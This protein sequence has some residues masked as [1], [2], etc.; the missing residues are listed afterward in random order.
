MDTALYPVGQICVSVSVFSSL[1]QVTVSANRSRWDWTISSLIS[2]VLFT[3]DLQL[4]SAHLIKLELL[5]LLRRSIVLRLDQFIALHV[6]L[7]NWCLFWLI[8]RFVAWC[9]TWLTQ[10]YIWWNSLHPALDLLYF[11]TNLVFLKPSNITFTHI[12][13]PR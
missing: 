13:W 12:S 1:I 7:V 3:T 5:W 10:V 8:E 6:I 2:E 4:T 9:P 11:F